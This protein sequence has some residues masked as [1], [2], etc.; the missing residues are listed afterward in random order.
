MSDKDEIAALVRAQIQARVVE[1]LNA[2]PEVVEKLVTAAMERPVDPET[3]SPPRYPNS[4]SVPY[5]EWLTASE[6][7]SA[8]ARAMREHLKARQSEI[9]KAVQEWLAAQ[10]M[11]Q[12]IG[13][14]LTSQLQSALADA[15]ITMQVN[16][17]RRDD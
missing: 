7:Q 11:G 10:P 12:I 5:L 3:G 8:V 14:A 13:S 17:P 1:A 6:L 9:D 2:A 4:K 16:I 15:F